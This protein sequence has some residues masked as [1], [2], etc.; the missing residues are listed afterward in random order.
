MWGGRVILCFVM[1]SCMSCAAVHRNDSVAG[2]PAG[3]DALTGPFGRPA[4]Y[5]AGRSEPLLLEAAE[6]REWLARNE[7][8]I[9]EIQ[10]RITQI[11][12]GSRAAGCIG[13]DKFTCIATLAQTLAIADQYSQKDVNIFAEIRYDVNGKP[14]N[15]SKIMFDGY[16]PDV[17]IERG[18]SSVIEAR[19]YV[20]H[21]VVNLGPQNIVVSMLAKLPGV[22]ITARTQEEYDKTTLYQTVWAA[23]VKACPTVGPGEVAKWIENSVKPTARLRPR[24]RLSEEV[25]AQEKVSDPKSFCGRTFKF[26]MIDEKIRH[27]FGHEH[28]VSMIIEIG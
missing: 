23:A 25:T 24:E 16:L 12:D 7:R 5:Y 2:Q 13:E 18:Y 27:G 8:G 26:H 9:D 19:R 21:Y 22:S 10:R 14:I 15:G 1:L 3:P 4:G 11:R 28:E 17:K 20:T 6:F